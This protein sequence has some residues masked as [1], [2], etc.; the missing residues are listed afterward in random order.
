MHVDCAVYDCRIGE[1]RVFGT[2]APVDCAKMPDQWSKS[3]VCLVVE[4]LVAM[5]CWTERR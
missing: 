1:L 5:R 3:G 4:K 2:E